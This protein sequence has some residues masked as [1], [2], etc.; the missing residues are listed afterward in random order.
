MEEKEENRS[1]VVRS[2]VLARRNQRYVILP[3]FVVENL[4]IEAGRF[5]T[6][7]QD[8][9]HRIIMETDQP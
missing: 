1:K 8:G 6:I 3:E 2:K 7:I 9:A 5:V 4:G